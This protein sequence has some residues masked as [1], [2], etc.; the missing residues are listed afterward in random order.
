[1]TAAAVATVF[2][3]TGVLFLVALRRF[4]TRRARRQRAGEL[5]KRRSGSFSPFAD[6]SHDGTAG[7]VAS[8]AYDALRP[9][10]RTRLGR[11]PAWQVETFYHSLEVLQEAREVL[12]RTLAVSDASRMGDTIRA[13]TSWEAVRGKAL[14]AGECA[15][16]TLERL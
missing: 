9:L 4:R 10:A 7:E 14:A 5:L 13:K 8:P 11:E 15:I 1:M 16:A 6:A 2:T 3:G 12:K